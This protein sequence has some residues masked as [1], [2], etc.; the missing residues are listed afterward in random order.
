MDEGLAPLVAQT[1]HTTIH[2]V[3]PRKEQPWSMLHR[4]AQESKPDL[5][6]SH[7]REMIEK[8]ITT[9]R[10]RFNAVL[11][12]YPGS[13]ILIESRR[14]ASGSRV[15]WKRSDTNDRGR[16]QLRPDVRPTHA[17]DQDGSADARAWQR[18]A[19]TGHI[20]RRIG[21]PTSDAIYE[22]SSPYASLGADRSRYISLIKALLRRDGLRLRSGKPRVVL[23]RW[24]KSICWITSTRDQTV[25]GVMGPLGKAD[26]SVDRQVGIWQRRTRR[27]ARCARLRVSVL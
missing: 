27:C 6:S 1:A 21:P 17:S 18:R 5:A 20:D 13:R 15:A 23:E 11:R 26:R 12:S 7:R 14:R 16:S 10:E 9:E 22:G 24:Q 3:D 19:A 25:A 4:R 2:R 8:T